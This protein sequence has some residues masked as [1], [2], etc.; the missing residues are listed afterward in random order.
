MNSTELLC[1]ILPALAAFLCGSIPFGFIVARSKGVDIRQQGSGNIGA[2]NV[3]RVLGKKWGYLVLAL[4]ALKGVIGV[5]AAPHICA[6][7]GAAPAGWLDL[8]CGVAAVMGH[9]Y[10]PWLGWK[11][12]KGI[13]T[14]AGVLTVVFPQQFL[15][16]FG[17]WVLVFLTSGYVSLASIAG[18]IALGVSGFLIDG[19][20]AHGI[21][22]LL[23]GAVAIL[24]HKSN[25]ARLVA[26]TENRTLWKKKDPA[27]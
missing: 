1:L 11:G 25:I 3:G 23:L 9:N 8:L 12:G 20:T 18:G 27:P 17:S 22:A 2:T 24:R 15:W 5:L 26:G 10:C 21:A 4:D 6:R 16:V 19:L 14:T 13:A 7:L